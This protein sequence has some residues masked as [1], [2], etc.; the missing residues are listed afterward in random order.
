MHVREHPGAEPWFLSSLT[1]SATD[2]PKASPTQ[3]QSS[4]P[5]LQPIVFSVA[6][7]NP[8]LD[9]KCDN[10]CAQ[11]LLLQHQEQI[12]AGFHPTS[13]SSVCA[14]SEVMQSLPMNHSWVVHVAWGLLT[15]VSGKKIFIQFSISPTAA[16][17]F[18]TAKCAKRRIKTTGESSPNASQR[19]F[20]LINT[21]A[22][23][24]MRI[25]TCSAKILHL[26]I[27]LLTGRQ[28]LLRQ[29]VNWVNTEIVSPSLCWAKIKCFSCHL[30]SGLPFFFFSFCVSN[31]TSRITFCWGLKK[32]QIAEVLWSFSDRQRSWGT[33]LAFFIKPK[34]YVS[35]TPSSSFYRDAVK[36]SHVL[37]CACCILCLVLL[38]SIA[39]I[40][41]PQSLH[42]CKVWSGG[43]LNQVRYKDS[44][45]VMVL[46]WL[47][48][49]W[50]L[51]F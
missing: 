12:Q 23:V 9:V 44:A 19:I 46:A 5:F 45:L 26:H 28:Y 24:H 50:G 13:Q 40:L 30:T 10:V 2:V 36:A 1:A 21:L 43:D 38:C 16:C 6:V 32:G 34:S 42:K 17:G 4:F 41:K 8:H 15:C 27:G 3:C 49:T 11:F 18:F 39:W 48:R 14:R 22:N 7:T 33:I 25:C 51:L 37:V 31:N 29:L 35:M 20:D 47:K